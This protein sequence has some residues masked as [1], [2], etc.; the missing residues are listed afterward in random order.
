VSKQRPHFLLGAK[1]RQPKISKRPCASHSRCTAARSENGFSTLAA[2]G[3]PDRIETATERVGHRFPPPWSVEDIGA[4]FVVKDS[5]GQQL[6]YVYFEEEPGRRL[7]DI[8]RRQ[9]D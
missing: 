4:A 2:L 6:A 5:G 3:L 8:R 9:C 7:P 1:A